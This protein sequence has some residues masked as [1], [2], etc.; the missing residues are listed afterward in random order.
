MKNLKSLRED[1][2]IILQIKMNE[3]NI[4]KA[5]LARMIDVA[6]TSVHRYI[7][8]TAKPRDAILRKIAKALHCSMYEFF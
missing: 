4:N 8:G 7:K 3:Q 6:D 5:D 1:F 2:P